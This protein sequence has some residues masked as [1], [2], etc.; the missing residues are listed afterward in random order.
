MSVVSTT[1]VHLTTADEG[2]TAVQIP[3]DGFDLRKTS[4]SLAMYLDTPGVQRAPE[5]E[6]N[7]SECD[8]QLPVRSRHKIDEPGRLH[9]DLGISHTSALTSPLVVFA[10]CEHSCDD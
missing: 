4:V 8:S 2:Q 10:S 6:V 7:A 5:L 3:L 9:C 1:A